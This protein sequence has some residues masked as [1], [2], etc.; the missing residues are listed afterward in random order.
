MNNVKYIIVLLALLVV[1]MAANA[2]NRRKGNY[3]YYDWLAAVESGLLTSLDNAQKSSLERIIFEFYN[4]GYTDERKLA[5]IIATCWHESK[6]RPIEEIRAREGTE[7]RKVQDRYWNTGYYGRGL[8][9]ITW[10]NNYR[11]V[12][13]Y[14]GVNL[15]SNPQKALDTNIAAKIAVLGMMKGWFTRLSLFA[16]INAVITDYYNARRTV[17]GTDKAGLIAGYTRQIIDKIGIVS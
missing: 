1:P 5:Y 6:L 17:N 2:T 12:G 4:N 15:E 9:Q 14:I 10:R 11:K 16:F 13:N 8:V 7:L 3:T